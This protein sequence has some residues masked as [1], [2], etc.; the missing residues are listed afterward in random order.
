[1]PKA[2]PSRTGNTPPHH[3]AMLIDL[4]VCTGCAACA[5]ACRA[6]NN[7]AITGPREAARN[8]TIQWLRIERGWT[9]AGSDFHVESRPVTC[10]QCGDAP[11]EPVC[12]VLATY[13]NPDGLSVQVYNRCVGTRYCAINCPYEA[14]FFNWF[15][16][17]W[18]APMELQLNP[19][20]SQRTRGIMEKCSFCVQRIEAAERTA[21]TERRPVR[22]G[23]VQPACAQSCPAE[24]ILFGDLNDPDS[25]IARAWRRTGLETLL[26]EV[27]T[28]PA[29]RYVPRSDRLAGLAPPPDTESPA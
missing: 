28:L 7:V 10:Q 23:E 20:V 18:P 1:M 17:R 3:W 25:R 14:R 2:E 8:G 26:E 16:Y 12:P 4:N 11:C 27:G 24:A 29:V 21:L 19:D 9:G 15:D 22:D 6:E 13:T 5:V